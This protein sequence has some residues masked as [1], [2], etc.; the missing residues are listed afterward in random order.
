[1]TKDD[2]SSGS[3]EVNGGSSA[4][5]LP[6]TDSELKDS[7]NRGSKHSTPKVSV[8][9]ATGEVGED[10]GSD[11]SGDEPERKQKVSFNVATTAADSSNSNSDDDSNANL[12][13]ENMGGRRRGFSQSEPLKR[14]KWDGTLNSDD[15]NNM[16]GGGEGERERRRKKKE[17]ELTPK[18]VK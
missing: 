9:S 16:M 8:T 10:G 1:M 11:G 2:P 13:R 12:S 7:R 14:L 4:S 18:E 15:V 3:S 6:Q 17:E 5:T